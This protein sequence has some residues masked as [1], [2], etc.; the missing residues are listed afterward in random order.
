ML[1]DTFFTLFLNFSTVFPFMTEKDVKMP[2]KMILT[3]IQLPKHPFAGSNTQPR[4][5]FIICYFVW[6]GTRTK[7]VLETFL[8]LTTWFKRK[9]K[10]LV[11]NFFPLSPSN[12]VRAPKNFERRLQKACESQNQALITHKPPI[13]HIKPT[14]LQH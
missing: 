13:K 6:S 8:S 3:T 9:T 2:K 14:S 5:L 7:M 11:P 12:S 4:Y 10:K 1:V